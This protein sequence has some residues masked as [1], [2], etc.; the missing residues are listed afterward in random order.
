MMRG[1]K[2]IF[3]L[4]FIVFLNISIY[5]QETIRFGQPWE[6]NGV[7]LNVVRIDVRTSQS[8]QD[9]AIQVWFYF[10]NYSG[11]RILV[12]IDWDAIYIIDNQGNKYIDWEGG[13]TNRW[14][15]T[16]DNYAFSRYYTINRGNVAEFLHN[17]II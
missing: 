13:I 15:D 3:F 6:N 1:T 4:F 10:F 11:Q 5:A 8:S 9:A 17:L 2:L 7:S 16:G 14:V 12:D